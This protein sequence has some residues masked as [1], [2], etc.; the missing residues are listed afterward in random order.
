MQSVKTLRWL[1][2]RCANSEDT[3]GGLELD[4]QI[5]KTL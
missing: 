1:R 5:V 3:L 2:A 4:V